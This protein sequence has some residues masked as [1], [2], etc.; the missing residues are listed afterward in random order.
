MITKKFDKDIIINIP[1][2]IQKD[3]NFFERYIKN[4]S[5]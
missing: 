5:I 2:D 3:S 4:T 1:D